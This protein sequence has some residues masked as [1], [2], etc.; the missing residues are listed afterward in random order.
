MMLNFNST[1]KNERERGREKKRERES[2][3]EFHLILCPSSKTKVQVEI[4][5][6]SSV[7]HWLISQVNNTW[8]ALSAYSIKSQVNCAYFSVFKGPLLV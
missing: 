1:V 2:Y 5:C 4:Q 3:K 7:I 8:R 6:G